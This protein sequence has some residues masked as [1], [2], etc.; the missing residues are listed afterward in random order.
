MRSIQ[1]HVP[2]LA[3]GVAACAL[4][5]VSMSQGAPQISPPRVSYGPHPRDMVQIKE[6]TPYVVPTGTVFTVTGIGSVYNSAI[7]TTILVDNMQELW[8]FNGGGVAGKCSV[9]DVPQGLTVQAGQTITVITGTSG[10]Q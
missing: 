9:A 10:G 8:A 7:N 1:L 2:S 4:L 5:L 3:I 6:G